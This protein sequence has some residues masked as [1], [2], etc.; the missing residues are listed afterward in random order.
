M[1]VPAVVVGEEPAEATAAVV[2][3]VAAELARVVD[4]EAATVA[5]AA[6]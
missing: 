2:M 6:P 5:E 4:M 1:E 3:G